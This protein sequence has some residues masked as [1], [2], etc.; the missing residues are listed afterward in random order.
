MADKQKIG[1]GIMAKLMNQDN[2]P[3]DNNNP[4]KE[5][6]QVKDNQQ[7]DNNP[8]DKV[9]KLNKVVNVVELQGITAFFYEHTLEQIENILHAAAKKKI[10]HGEKKLNRNHIIALAVQHFT[11]H[12]I[13]NDNLVNEVELVDMVNALPLS[14]VKKYE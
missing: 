1:N 8:V 6:N 3:V 10:R 14:R 11:N 13:Q 4:V 5:G 12:F 7:V 2:N 9:V